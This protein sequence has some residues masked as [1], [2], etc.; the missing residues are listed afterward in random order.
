[1]YLMM[2]WQF[3]NYKVIYLVEIFTD[4]NEKTIY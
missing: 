3:N 1:M 2:N 4:C